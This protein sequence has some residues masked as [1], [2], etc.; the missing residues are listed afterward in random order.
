M[1]ETTDF[2]HTLESLRKTYL[3]VSTAK[4]MRPS[5]LTCVY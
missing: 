2:N 1:V 5:E 4:Q 3:L